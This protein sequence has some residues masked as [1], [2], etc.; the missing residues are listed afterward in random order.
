MTELEYR[1]PKVCSDRGGYEMIPV[2]PVALDLGRVRQALESDGVD[3]L[4]ARVLLI[5]RLN[6]EAT[7]H[8]NG[9]VLVKSG[10]RATAETVFRRLEP[11]VRTGVGHAPRRARDA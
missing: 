5:A 11:L 8:A 10:D 7:I 4:D 1:P 9:R 3:V 2:R 6:P